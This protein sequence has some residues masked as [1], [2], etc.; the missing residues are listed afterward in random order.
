MTSGVN[1]RY[2]AK[3]SKAFPTKEIPFREP[4]SVVYWNHYSTLSRDGNYR[5]GTRQGVSQGVK[6]I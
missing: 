4:L 1:H 5:G 3:K 6:T 2:G